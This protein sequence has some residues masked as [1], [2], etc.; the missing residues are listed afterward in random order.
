LWQ[1]ENYTI[2]VNSDVVF[3]QRLNYVHWNPVTAGFV[4]KQWHWKCGSAVD[5]LT[6][7]KGLLNL[8]MLD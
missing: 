7:K 1:H 3:N 5:Y 6:D 8:V 4:L 2:L